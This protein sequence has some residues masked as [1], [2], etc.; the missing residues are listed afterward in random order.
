MKSSLGM[1]PKCSLKELIREVLVN[2]G[3]LLVSQIQKVLD[4]PLIQKLNG[5]FFPGLDINTSILTLKKK[6]PVTSC[7]RN[8]SFHLAIFRYIQQPLA[9]VAFYNE[10]PRCQNLKIQ[11]KIRW[12]SRD[13]NDPPPLPLDVKSENSEK[14][15]KI[16][17]RFLYGFQGPKCPQLQQFQDLKN[18][19][20]PTAFGSRATETGPKI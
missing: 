7:P 17:G 4:S 10:P 8:H 11:K 2:L 15:R 6:L 12:G 3:C 14:I 13:P 9:T 20:R 1:V 16:S 19:E 5:T 18:P